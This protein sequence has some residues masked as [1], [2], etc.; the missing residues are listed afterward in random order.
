MDCKFSPIVRGITYIIFV[1]TQYLH[2]YTD[3]FKK[4]SLQ[5][6]CPFRYGDLVPVTKIGRTFTVIWMLIGLVITSMVVGNLSSILT[7]D[8]AIGKPRIE[9]T[10]RVRK[11]FFLNWNDKRKTKTKCQ[12]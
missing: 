2:L 6:E 10:G 8:F 1:I 7:I 11:Y 9:A 5:T 12:F 4:D 3:G